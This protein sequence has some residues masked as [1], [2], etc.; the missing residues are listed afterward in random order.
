M[1]ELEIKELERNLTL[2]DS[3]KEEKKSADGTDNELGE[4]V[5]G[6]LAAMEED[7]EVSNLEEE[8]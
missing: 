5:R 4:E 7:E 8:K 6:I 3:C 2:N 1:T